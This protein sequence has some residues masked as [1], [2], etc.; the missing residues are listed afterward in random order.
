[1]KLCYSEE[2]QSARRVSHEYLQRQRETLD[3]LDELES[4]MGDMLQRQTEIEV[5]L[6]SLCASFRADYYLDRFR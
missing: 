1:M 2:L 4:I 5:R 3:D 6:R